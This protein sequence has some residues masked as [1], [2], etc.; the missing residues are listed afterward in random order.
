MEI[1]NYFLV[2]YETL[3]LR[4]ALRLRAALSLRGNFEGGLSRN[5]G[6]VETLRTGGDG[7]NCF[8]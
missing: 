8:L 6:I 5:S 2:I 7:N 1:C 4:V 3:W